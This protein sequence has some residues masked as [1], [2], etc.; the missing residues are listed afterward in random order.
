MGAIALTLV[1]GPVFG[2]DR[3]EPVTAFV[4]VHVVP[5]DRE[6]FLP[7]RTV[8]VR[9]E[10]IVRIG[11]ANATEIPDGTRVID[12]HGRYLMPGLADMHVHVWTEGDLLLYVANGVTTIRNMSGAPLHLEWRERIAKGELLGPTL[13]TAGPIVDGNPP[14][15]SRSAVVETAEQ[16]RAVVAEQKQAGYDFLKVYGNLSKEA[17]DATLAAARAHDM[18]VVGHVPT[19][20]TL[21]HALLA[22]QRSIEHLSGYERALTGATLDAADVPYIRRW[23]LAWE[24]MDRSRLANLARKTREA[25]AWVCPT[26]GVFDGRFAPREQAEAFLA[27]PET[28]FVSPLQLHQWRQAPGDAELFRRHRA[29]DAN[30]RWVTKELW[31]TT[32]RV[33][34]GTDTA[35]PFLV[36][37]FSIHGEL[38]HL[39]EA[40]LTPYEALRAGTRNPAEFLGRL[41]EFGTVAEGL[42]ADLILLEANPLEDVGNVRKCA[43]VM[44]RGRWLPQAELRSRLRDLAEV[45]AT[46]TQPQGLCRR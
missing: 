42:R 22:G 12:G 39:V 17:Y 1:V 34:L 29:S 13:V 24:R 11:A 33:L 3:T 35:N 16:A 41:D 45:Y 37:G 8:F 30:R 2:A 31:R 38:R 10:R 36:P 7:D 27:R 25:G 32:G 15:W 4:G 44:L 5:M 46:E 19:A 26:L 18:P 23:A 14:S 28:R 9:G 6:R 20:V 21:E 40:G 43:G